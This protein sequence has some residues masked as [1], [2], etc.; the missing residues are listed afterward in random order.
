MPCLAHA[1][2]Y[3]ITGNWGISSVE[4]IE[5]KHGNLV[6][7]DQ[8]LFTLFLAMGKGEVF[9]FQQTGD[10]FSDDDGDNGYIT[11][12]SYYYYPSGSETTPLFGLDITSSQTASRIVLSDA[13]QGIFDF[14][15]QLSFT[16]NYGTYYSGTFY[17]KYKIER[18]Y[19]PAE[20]DAAKQATQESKSKVV[21]VPLF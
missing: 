2:T 13:N 1:A 7:Y 20:Y 19:T 10:A 12:A 18:F 8:T 3:D 6:N 17:C 5:Y 21:V 9:I 11:G 16:D 14:D 4:T 15:I